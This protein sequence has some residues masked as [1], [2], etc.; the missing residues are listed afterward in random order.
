MEIKLSKYATKLLDVL[1]D[2]L[3]VEDADVVVEEAVIRLYKSYLEKGEITEGRQP[4]SLIESLNQ[5]GFLKRQFKGRRNALP[6]QQYDIEAENEEDAWQ[7]MAK[8]F[9]EEVN[10]GFIVE[11]VESIDFGKL[12]L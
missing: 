2:H 12:D 11:E 9:P 10:Q 4:T 7:Q 3:Q 1:K 5:A 8:R 6:K